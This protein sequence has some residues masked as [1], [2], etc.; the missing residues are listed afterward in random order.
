MLHINIVG[1]VT[2][3]ENCR[4]VTC[5][6]S[7]DLFSIHFIIT[8]HIS[9][10]ATLASQYKKKKL[11][12]NKMYQF[13]S[14]LAMSCLAI[15]MVRHFHVRHFLRPRWLVSGCLVRL[16]KFVCTACLLLWEGNTRFH[17]QWLPRLQR[18]TCYYRNKIR[19]MIEWISVLGQPFHSQNGGAV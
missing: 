6:L 19:N 8:L 10:A 18:Q 3:S 15:L 1:V 5:S 13:L 14:C 2:C 17:T 11:K 9:I 7:L 16:W 12:L 4:L